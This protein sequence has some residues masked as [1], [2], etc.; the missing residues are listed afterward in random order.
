MQ[1]SFDDCPK[2]DNAIQERG[3]V[4][5]EGDEVTVAD[6]ADSV[7]EQ[8]ICDERLFLSFEVPNGGADLQRGTYDVETE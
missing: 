4:E 8:M 5:H 7:L 3:V 6:G 1:K 2:C